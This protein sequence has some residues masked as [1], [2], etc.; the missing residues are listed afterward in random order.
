MKLNIKYTS[1]ALA[2]ILF[3]G[4]GL[5]CWPCSATTNQFAALTSGQLQEPYSNVFPQNNISY[6]NP[7]ECTPGGGAGLCGDTSEEKMWSLL[8][9]HFDALHAAAAFGSINHEG[10]SQP[11]KWEYNRIVSTSTCQFIVNWDDI[12]N[13]AYDG[14]YG[15]GSFGLTS[16]LSDYL[17]YVGDTAP[18]LL[19]YFKDPTNTCLSTGDELAEKIGENAY[20]RLVQ[21]EVNY[22][23]EQWIGE[24][25]LNGF[26][27]ID[28]LEEAAV[29]WAHNIERCAACGYNGGSGQLPLR[30]A[31]A[32]KKYDEFKDFTCSASSNSS[33]ASSATPSS[34]S[35]VSGSQI[36][37]IG[38]SLTGIGGEDL[39]KQYFDGADYGS[40]FNKCYQGDMSSYVCSGKKIDSDMG[41]NGGPS[42]LKILEDIVSAKKLRPILVFA[43]GANSQWTQAYMDKLRSLVGDDT[44]VLILTTKT[45]TPHSL[46]GGGYDDNNKFLK[47]AAEKYDNIYVADWA[48]A[49]KDENY[50]SDGL[51]YKSPDGYKAYYQFISDSLGNLGGDNCG[52]GDNN[53]VKA[54][55]EIIE[56]ANKNGSTYGGGHGVE[57]SVFDGML[58]NGDPI[59]VDCT[60]FV[61]LV[62]YKAFGQNPNIFTGNIDE[63][64][65]FEEVQLKDVQPGDAF[66]YDPKWGYK[67]DAHGGIVLEVDNGKVTKIA[68]VGGQEGRS[69]DKNKNVGYS[70]GDGVFT[71]S[72]INGSN[73]HFFRWKGPKSGTTTGT[74]SACSSICDDGNSSGSHPGGFTSV[75]EADKTIMEPY[76]ALFDHPESWKPE[77]YLT[78]DK[79]P[80]NCF[81]FANYFISQYTSIKNFHG[82]TGVDAGAYVKKFYEIYHDENPDIKLSDTP[83]AYGIG[84]CG[85]EV[86]TGSNYSHVFVVLGITG[87]KMIIGEAGYGMG[88]GYTKA[89]EVSL[90]NVSDANHN[91][92]GG[93]PC[94]FLDINAYMKGL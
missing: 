12:W 71:I 34:G 3:L 51:H 56:L 84:S 39:F 11:V 72:N 93:T 74:S 32:S 80:D 47:E 14:R 22:F 76:R 19:E 64:E 78:S 46:A 53:V 30:A 29:Y 81:S 27:S 54:A 1:I 4:L 63:S 66:A 10:G 37:F 48:T 57:N 68:E 52:G 28:N 75:E 61:N 8:S 25:R 83:V 35:S 15:V 65:Y 20:D 91:G 92:T 40:S 18:D 88:L 73:G 23:I 43:L 6:W 86:F 49:V 31:E 94:T 70:T 17:H 85:D 55:E 7:N 24:D 79:G 77:Y 58:K 13:G 44:K 2:A 42:G 50:D 41:T 16:G 9:Q 5:F 90:T 26:K 33:G 21:L 59:K 69:G 67:G 60:G 36:T 87:D 62:M 82:V 38:D 89:K 45:I